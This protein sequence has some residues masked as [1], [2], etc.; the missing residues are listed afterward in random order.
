MMNINRGPFIAAIRNLSDE[1]DVNKV[2]IREAGG[3]PLIISIARARDQ[4]PPNQGN[5]AIA[6]IHNMSTDGAR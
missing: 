3:I 2:A 6:L 5:S 1:S 4:L